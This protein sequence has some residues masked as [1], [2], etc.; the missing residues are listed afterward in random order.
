[1]QNDNQKNVGLLSQNLIISNVLKHPRIPCYKTRVR[2]KTFLKKTWMA[3]ES[4]ASVNEI[5]LEKNW[6]K[7]AFC[8]VTVQQKLSRFFI[9]TTLYQHYLDS[10]PKVLSAYDAPI[11][12]MAICWS[13]IPVRAP[14]QPC[15]PKFTNWF[16]SFG[17]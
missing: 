11:S 4:F 13:F 6:A 16:P 3:T 12:E 1:M 2:K 9:L 8:L 5:H 14:I 17:W 7:Q 15:H 10:V